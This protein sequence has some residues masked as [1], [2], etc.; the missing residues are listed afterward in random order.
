MIT[1][2]YEDLLN[3]FFRF[4]YSLC[5]PFH[6]LAY[7]ATLLGSSVRSYIISLLR[8]CPSL[9]LENLYRDCIDC[10]LGEVKGGRPSYGTRMVIQLLRE[11]RPELCS[12]ANERVRYLYHIV[13]Q[14]S[15]LAAQYE[16]G[17]RKIILGCIK[18]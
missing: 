4:I 7:P 6:Y 9:A 1:I 18:H 15:I 2:S 11:S 17:F 3:N 8:I 14:F 10:L 12:A 16:L 13:L 5:V